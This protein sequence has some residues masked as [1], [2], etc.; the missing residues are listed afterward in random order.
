VIPEM[1][2]WL[3]H[4]LILAALRLLSLAER[5]GDADGGDYL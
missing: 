2:C 5:L 3:A 4:L 1:L